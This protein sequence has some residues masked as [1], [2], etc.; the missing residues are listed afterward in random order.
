MFLDVLPWDGSGMRRA[1]IRAGLRFSD[2]R[3]ERSFVRDYTRSDLQ[4]TRV[5]M[6]VGCFVYVVFT[7]W[8]RVLDPMAWP[9]TAEMRIAVVLLVL[10]P[11]TGL[12][13]VERARP[14][15]EWLLLLY[16]AIPAAILPVIYGYLNDGFRHGAA[17]IVIIVLFVLILLPMR[18]TFFAAFAAV[19][20]VS[21]GLN[22]VLSRDFD[23]AQFSVNQLYCG[24]AAILSLYSA[25]VRERLARRQFRT[26]AAL[27][28]SKDTA[29]KALEDLQVARESLVQSEKLASLGQLVSGLAHELNTPIGT[30]L[31]I[32]TSLDQGVRDLHRVIASGRITK[33]ELGRH[34]DH[35][36][37]GVALVIDNLSRTVDLVGAFKQVSSD[38]PDV[39]R[40]SFMVAPWLGDFL[41][42]FDETLNATGHAIQAKCPDGFSI[43][44]DP[45]RLEQV[46]RNLI[47]NALAHAFPAGRPGTLTVSF[48]RIGENLVRIVVADDGC[49]IAPDH[50][51]KIFDPFFTTARGRGSSGLGLPIV[52]NMV[53][54]AGGRISVDSE[55]D[56]GTRVTIDLPQSLSQS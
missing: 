46:L 32:S 37:Q 11:L 43:H 3:E 1:L 9:T 29:D 21:F 35:L 4:Q 50:L 31:T 39:E 2:E 56:A 47:G 40:L 26:T 25:Q 52:H 38:R 22:E 13:F 12:T 7:A 16:S 8:D 34:V 5:A 15:L 27:Q 14:R 55:P 41:R 10:L 48:A 6:L 28:A 36:K 51:G 30:A 44:A 18:V 19:I 49:G 45:R 42:G 23:L 53:V 24:T 17:G 54:G 33:S 20:W